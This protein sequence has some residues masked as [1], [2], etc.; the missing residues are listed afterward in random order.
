MIETIFDEQDLAGLRSF[1]SQIQELYPPLE[2][3]KIEFTVP[4]LVDNYIELSDTYAADFKKSSKLAQEKLQI[5]ETKVD[6]GISRTRNFSDQIVDRSGDWKKAFQDLIGGIFG[7]DVWIV[8]TFICSPAGLTIVA[9]VLNATIFIPEFT[10]F[11]IE[12]RE[13]RKHRNYEEET[14][15]LLKDSKQNNPSNSNNYSLLFDLKSRIYTRENE[16]AGWYLKQKT[17]ENKIK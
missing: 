9:F 6:E 14:L 12:Y 16:K 17:N 5:F 4:N 11:F 13:H 15:K 10:V 2:V 1:D 8:L 7:K 3:P